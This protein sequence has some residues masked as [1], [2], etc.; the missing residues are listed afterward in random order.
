MKCLLYTRFRL[1]GSD[2]FEGTQLFEIDD[3]PGLSVECSIFFE[4]MGT[5]LELVFWG[6]GEFS[7]GFDVIS[8]I[9]ENH[10]RE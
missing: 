1:H 4:P 9:E 8:W 2:Y 10:L 3:H 7:S 5:M 6:E